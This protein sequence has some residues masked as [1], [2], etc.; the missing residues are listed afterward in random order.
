MS[1]LKKW[2][3]VFLDIYKK[4]ID[5]GFKKPNEK[6]FALLMVVFVIALATII[7][8]SFSSETFAFIR[9]NRTIS[10]GLEAELAA[11]SALTLALSILELPE[12]PSTPLQPWQMFNSLPSVPIPGYQGELR[13]QIIDEGGKININSIVSSNDAFP[14][15]SLGSNQIAGVGSGITQGQD[16]A[17]E[18]W[19]VAL[20][21]L[22]AQLG[23]QASEN[24]VA[25]IHDN[26]DIDSIAHQSSTF[27]GRGIETPSTTGLFLNKQI[28]SIEELSRVQGLPPG[29]LQRLGPHVRAGIGSDFR[30]NINTASIQVLKAIGFQD[31]EAA[32]IINK[33]AA[34]SIAPE[35]LQQLTRGSA[36]LARNATTNSNNFRILARAKTVSMTK[37]LESDVIVQSG[38]GKKVASVRRTRVY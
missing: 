24:T 36:S 19:K 4:N 3:K 1:R 21:S 7:V 10:D 33:R 34:G 25:I 27:P 29:F 14:G 16:E 35:E 2:L 18:G 32:E 15:S 23:V 5:V 6:G 8:T 22:F 12:D 31:Q 30:V 28:K 37:W 9:S 11:R 26:L 17:S 38:F 20:A 13:V